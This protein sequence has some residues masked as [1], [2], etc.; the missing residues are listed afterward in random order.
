MRFPRLLILICIAL[1]LLQAS[2]YAALLPEQIASHFDAAGRADGWSS[3]NSFL[4]LNLAF[5]VGMA[6][7]F[8]GVTYLI[9]TVPNDWINL[10]NKDYWLAPERRAATLNAISAQMEWLAAMTLALLLGMTQLTI[11]ANLE[12]G[13]GRL[14]GGFGFLFGAYMAFFGVWLVLLLRKWYAPPPRR[15]DTLGPP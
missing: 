4:A 14:S 15:D 6:L 11:Q 9:N 3:K 5:V 10:P 12:T 2:H 7:L 8:F 13:S 1:A